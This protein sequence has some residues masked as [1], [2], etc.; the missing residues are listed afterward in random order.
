[1]RFSPAVQRGCGAGLSDLHANH[2]SVCTRD[3]RL[4]LTFASARFGDKPFWLDEVTS[5]RRATAHLP[6]LATDSLHNGHYPTYFL[7]LWLVAKIG[8]SQSLLR[9]PSAVF[10]AIAASLTCAIGNRVSGLRGGVIA[11]LLMALS[12]FQVQFGQE[13]R[14]YTLASSLILTALYGLVRL[15]QQPAAAAVPLNKRGAL[16]QAWSAYGL[17]TAAALDVLNIAIPWF[18]AANFAALAIARAAGSAKYGFWRNW[19]TV[20][21]LIVGVWAPMVAL[22]WLNHSGTVLDGAGWVPAATSKTIWSAMAP[23]YLLRIS[24][25]VTL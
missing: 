19:I 23:V 24:S 3:R 16:W 8:S 14:S 22:V 5:L 9:L 4:R 11:G 7:L 12:P 17:G 2:W 13:A 6:D 20:Q 1:M 25:F 18:I 21:L 15:T 10:G